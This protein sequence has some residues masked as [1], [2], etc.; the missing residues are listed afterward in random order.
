MNDW[1]LF[2]ATLIE[3]NNAVLNLE[4]F[5]VDNVHEQ[6]RTYNKPEIVTEV[7]VAEHNEV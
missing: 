5:S 6:N 7:V 4:V 3:F 1:G 2:H